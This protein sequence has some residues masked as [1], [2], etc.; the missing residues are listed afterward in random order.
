[1]R[2]INIYTKRQTSDCIKFL[3]NTLVR[4]MKKKVELVALIFY[5]NTN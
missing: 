3:V 5:Q 4:E 1:L 2:L